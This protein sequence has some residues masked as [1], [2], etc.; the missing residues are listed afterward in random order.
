[1]S[2]FS[3]LKVCEI[4]ITPVRSRRARIARKFVVFLREF[5]GRDFNFSTQLTKGIA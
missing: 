5:W 4:Y 1:M 3:H 2:D